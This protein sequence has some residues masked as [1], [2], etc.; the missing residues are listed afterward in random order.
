M[1]KKDKNGRWESGE[2]CLKIGK[3][4]GLWKRMSN[5]GEVWVYS[6][7]YTLEKMVYIKQKKVEK[8]GIWKKC[9]EKVE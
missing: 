6:M 3:G 4:R 5:C 8:M 1:S 7:L 2:K 9:P